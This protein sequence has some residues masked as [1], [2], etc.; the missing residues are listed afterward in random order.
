MLAMIFGLMFMVVSM[1]GIISWWPDFVNLIK[2][3]FPFMFLCG[4]LIAL[5]TGVSSVVDNI[6]TKSVYKNNE[7]ETK[8]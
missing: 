7:E 6:N 4:G 5:I 3:L 1:W 2:G 8:K